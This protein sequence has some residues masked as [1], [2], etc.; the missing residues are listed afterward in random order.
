MRTYGRRAFVRL[1]PTAGGLGMLAACA[2]AP[3][4]TAPSAP[5][6]EEGIIV[7]KA[8]AAAPA[9]AV[10]LRNF[11]RERFVDAC[12]DE[13]RMRVRLALFESAIKSES[14]RVAAELSGP[15]PHPGPAA[16]ELKNATKDKAIP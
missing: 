5:K 14:G 8:R 13:E 12:F 9:R 4:A 3:S 11:L 1:G 7:G 2:P 10:C 6:A 16:V 15:A